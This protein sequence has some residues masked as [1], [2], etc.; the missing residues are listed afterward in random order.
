M[1]KEKGWLQPRISIIRLM[2]NMGRSDE[3]FVVTED[4][5]LAGIHDAPDHAGRPG[6][7]DPQKVLTE[8]PNWEVHHLWLYDEPTHS[9]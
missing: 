2:W 6:V 8:G 1:M 7:H 4:H 5:Q 3:H 9:L